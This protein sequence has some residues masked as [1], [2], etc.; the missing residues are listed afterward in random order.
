MSRSARDRSSAIGAWIMAGVGGS[1]CR[2][3]RP[4]AV[5]GAAWRGRRPAGILW[6][7]KWSRT[8]PDGD[9]RSI[10][11]RQDLHGGPLGLSET[12]GRRDGATRGHPR[13]RRADAAARRAA[14]VVALRA[15]QRDG[16][17][18]LRA[19]RAALGVAEA[20]LARPAAHRRAVLRRTGR[21]ARDRS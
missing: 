20:A 17:A 6:D 9:Q 21:E 15:P 13:P 1:S 5:A 16:D 8:P 12:H 10:R 19:A 4:R 7:F 2:S 14:R 3:W 11:G 18:E